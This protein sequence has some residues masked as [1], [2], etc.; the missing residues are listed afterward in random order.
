MSARFKNSPESIFGRLLTFTFVC[1]VLLFI[2]G[3]VLLLLP[4]VANKIVAKIAGFG[5]II[6]GL[7]AIYNFRHREGAKIY[8]LN[9][10]FGIIYLFFGVM[11]V[12]LP[13]TSMSF[14]AVC[15]GI[16]LLV[17]GVKTMNY[18]RWLKVGNE[19]CWKVTLVSGIMFVIFAIMLFIDPFANWLTLTKIAGVFMMVT[20]VIDFTNTLMFKNRAEQIMSIFW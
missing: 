11:F 20:A 18:A 4:E 10:V 14:I 6:S 19:D 1:T 13:I 8:A 15:L 16:Y 12:L 9:L 17:N 3:L 7:N 2:I 5:L